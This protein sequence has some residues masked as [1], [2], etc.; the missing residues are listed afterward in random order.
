MKPALFVQDLQNVWLYEPE[1]NQ[2]L[3][4]SFEM[5]LERI[6]EA[7]DWF[8]ERGLPIIIGYT[9]DPE[10][11][12]IPGTEGFEVPGSLHVMQNDLKVTK[13]HANAFANPELGAVLK[14]NG[15]DTFL[16]LGLSAS[17]CV[18]AT[19][20]SAFDFDVR[21]FLVKGCV[22][23]ANEEHVRFAEDICDTVTLDDL[24]VQNS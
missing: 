11:G 24:Q 16:I 2:D 13:R 9:E 1:S 10:E 19:Y 20:F 3:R 6:N 5:R 21:P 8:R 15:C 18:L 14:R 4:K 23:S 7:I 17:G 12:I 22:A